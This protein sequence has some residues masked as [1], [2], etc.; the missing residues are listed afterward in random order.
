MPR[1]FFDVDDGDKMQ[2]DDTGVDLSGAD[3]A[4]VTALD[5]L[6]DVAREV[7]PNGDRREIKI[8]VRPAGEP[9]VFEA[10]LSLRAH[11]LR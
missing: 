10:V 6:P 4:R 3:I 7:L 1:Y 5:L 9:P 2:E 8:T 11:W